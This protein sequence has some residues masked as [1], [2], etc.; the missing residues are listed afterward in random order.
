M[1][2]RRDPEWLDRVETIG[3]KSLIKLVLAVVGLLLFLVFVTVL[4]GAQ[5]V[6]PGLP[7]TFA[8]LV[9]ALVTVAIVLLLVKVAVKARSAIQQL[10][11]DVPEVT[12]RSAVVGFWTVVFF[13]VVIAYEGFAAAVVPVLVE[14]SLRWTYDLLFFLLG[15]GPLLVIGYQ[16]FHLLDPLAE[17]VLVHL[18]AETE[19]DVSED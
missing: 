16:L 4:P 15:G 13:A 2:G 8:A 1:A 14:A 19:L 18:G 17:L 5:R 9:S 12:A 3:V 7:I 10:R 11:I 6:I